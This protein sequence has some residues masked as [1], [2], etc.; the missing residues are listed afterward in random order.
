L[1][2]DQK[3]LC[4][5]IG[6]IGDPGTEKRRH[7]DWLLKGIIRPVFET[8]FKDFDVQRADEITAPGSISAQVIIRLHSAELVIADMSLENANAFYELG[9]RHMKRLPTIH[10][11]SEGKDIPFD[12]KPYRAIPFKYLDPDDLT[13]AQAQLKAAVQ[14]VIKPGYVVDNPVTQAL[15]FEKLEE[16]ATPTEQV[17][18]DT[19]RALEKRVSALDATLVGVINESA[20]SRRFEEPR[21][22]LTLDLPKG[23]VEFAANQLKT[24]VRS[25]RVLK[26]SEEQLLVEVDSDL[27]A[28]RVQELARRL[29]SQGDFGIR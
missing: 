9:I 6:P 20:S 12:V 5:V 17:L 14:E 11:Y 3:K 1:A 28:L 4:F 19:V 26:R 18:L 22:L 25:A 13:A 2:E 24:S 10:M 27:D 7:S 21:H 8:N 16:T 15:G 29:K 23:T